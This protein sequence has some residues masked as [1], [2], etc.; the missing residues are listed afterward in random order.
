MFQ[1]DTVEAL[2]PIAQY[3]GPISGK[4]M[5]QPLTDHAVQLRKLIHLYPFAVGRI[6]NQYT[7]LVRRLGIL[8]KRLYAQ[9]DIL[10]QPGIPDI[11]LG[12]CD[13]FWRNVGTYDPVAE[14]AG[15]TVVV[16]DITESSL[17][18]SPHFEPEALPVNSR[19]DPE[20]DHR[21]LDQQCPT[22]TW[23]RQ[24]DSPRQPD[25]GSCPQQH[26]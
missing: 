4:E 2:F 25:F 3:I 11:F 13:R 17:S 15:T 14:L 20:S 16:I 9:V 23:G 24:V 19:R 5:L 26:R 21:R 8:L 12:N 10:L 7:L 6:C 18:K 22:R 1:S